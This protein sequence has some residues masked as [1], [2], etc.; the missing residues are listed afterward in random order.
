M[1]PVDPAQPAC[2]VPADTLQLFTMEAL[3]RCGVSEAEA[4]TAAG[5]L[6]ASDRRGIWSHG[7][8]RLENY[9]TML[10][11]GRINPRPKLRIVRETMSTALVDGDNGLG[12]VVGPWAN[13]RAME[14]AARAG[15]GWAA[16]R[17]SNHY[18]IAGYY[19]LQA[20]KRDLIGLSLTNSIALVAPFNGAARM[21]GTNPIAAGFPAGAEAPVVIDLATSAVPYG[22]VEQCARRHEPLKP[23]WA[24]DAT[25]MATLDPAAMTRGGA[26]SPLGSTADLGGHKGYCLGAMVDLLSAVLPGANWGPFAPPFKLDQPVPER[27]VGAGLGHFFGAW[28]IAAFEDPAVFKD[29]MDDWVRTM[30][31]ARPAPGVTQVQV[32]GEPERRAEAERAVSGIP[33][34]PAVWADLEKVAKLTGARLP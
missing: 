21:L 31:S 12:L 34:L 20:V 2:H 3:A 5:V 25:G 1:A 8:A 19:V 29:R 30:R 6:L 22:R 24:V 17:N 26:L 7:V 23:G 4:Q 14:M 10:Q 11:A 13:E 16:V 9:V 27:V 28:Q 18:G 32:P 33:I 15:S